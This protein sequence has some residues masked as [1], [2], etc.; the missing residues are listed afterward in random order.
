MALRAGSR[1]GKFLYGALFTLVLPVLLV[2]WAR[3]TSPIVQAPIISSKPLGIALVLAGLL[4]VFTGMGALL[5]HGQGLPMNP[6]PPRR[7]VTQGIYRFV[8]HPIYTGFS[9]LCVGTA[10]VAGSSSGFWLVSP[11]VALGCTALVLGYERHDLAARFGSDV[12]RPAAL[13]PAEGPSAPT[14]LEGINAFFCVLLPWVFLYESVVALGVPHDA[15]SAFLPFE[16]QLPVVEWTELIY[17]STYPLVALAPL[18]AGTRRDLRAFC[19]RGLL[20]MAVVFP[21]YLI[22]PLVAPPR[23]FTPHGV[24][25]ELLVWERAIDTPAA[26]FP[27]FLVIW[28]LLASSVF[29]ARMR[30]LRLLWRGWAL[31]VAVSCITTGMHAVADILAAFVV[32]VC[33]ARAA[34]VWARIREWAER[35]A[36]SW[37]EWR[38]GPVRV[39]SHG[40]YAGLAGFL[41]VFVAMMLAGPGHQGVVLLAACTGVVGAALWAQYIEGSAS[42]L[43]PYGYY[44]SLV[45]ISVGALFAP[46][47]GVS[48]WLVLAAFSVGAP[49]V[50]AIGRLRCLVQGCCHGRPAPAA[51]GIRYSH[52]QSRV[53]RLTEWAGVPLHPTP[54][55]SILWNVAVGVALARL[56]ALHARLGLIVGTYF[57]LSG[58]GRFVEEAYR[59][60]PQTPIFA[61]LRIYQWLAAGTVLLGALLTG[62]GHAI[63][64]PAR[65]FSIS[66]ALPALAFAL[67]TWFAMGV[68]FPN[69]NRRFSRLA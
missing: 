31:L 17:A 68:D 14:A 37:Q 25:G 48:V 13:L 69:S 2:V 6:Y 3:A 40:A 42:L 34:A 56:W 41:A 51:I 26:A 23:P 38:F 66:P 65:Q 28:A 44:G 36:N 53:C 21:L 49:W 47:F 67:F 19:V 12:A 58:L 15:V 33:V 10:I 4:L 61:R 39:M 64:A 30:S 24:L 5:V 45:G 22:V 60:E 52:P 63:P 20:S 55:Y 46:M 32:V 43:R 8:P 54:L 18:I 50:Q 59:G 1:L 29:A 11:L 7:Y 35:I 57:I 9:L 27:A 62:F 16:H